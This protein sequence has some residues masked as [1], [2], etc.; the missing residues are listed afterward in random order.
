MTGAFGFLTVRTGS[1]RL[2]AKCLLPFGE[3]NVLEHAIRR[4]HHFR[5]TPV[6]CTTILAEDDIIE[7]TA[8]REGA[9]CHRGSVTDKLVRWLGAARRFGAA[10]FHT[11]DVDDPFFDG[12]L[13]HDSLALLAQGYDAVYP[14]METFGGSVGFS[15]TTDL[16]ERVCAEKTSDDTEMMWYHIEKTP[17]LRHTVLK[18]PGAL[19]DNASLRLTLDYEEDYWMLMTVRRILGPFASRT[20]IENLLVANPAMSQINLFRNVDW[21]AGQLAKKV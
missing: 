21:K 15:L 9:L 14:S 4:A 2:A 16:L 10:E 1:S 13:G 6:V 18:V 5:F 3:G 20:A 7:Q 12:D 11:I 17:G 8:E 19:V